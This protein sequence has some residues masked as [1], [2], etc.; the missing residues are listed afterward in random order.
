MDYSKTT[1]EVIKRI[2]QHGIPIGTQQLSFQLRLPRVFIMREL[3]LLSMDK[4]IDPVG[5]KGWIVNQRGVDFLRN[6]SRRKK[7]L[8]LI[9][10]FDDSVL[11]KMNG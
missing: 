2:H 7:R 10:E 11:G 4:L 9:R 3:G 6:M 5:D 8:V 1:V